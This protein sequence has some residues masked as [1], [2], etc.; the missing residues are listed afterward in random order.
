MS[1]PRHE[2]NAL[3][4]SPV[5]FSIMGYLGSVDECEFSI[6]R[7]AVDLSD[8]SLSQNL[9]RLADAGFITIEKRQY[10]RQMRTWIASTEAGNQALRNN[11]LILQDIAGNGLDQE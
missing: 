2:L 6:L 5:R 10:G 9:T 11:L 1:H 3:I 7:D 4:H 8:S